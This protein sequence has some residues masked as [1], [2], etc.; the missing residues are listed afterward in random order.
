[1]YKVHPNTHQDYRSLLQK[2]VRRSDNT[3]VAKVVDC[4]HEIGDAAWL[5]RRTGVIIAEECWPLMAKWK[6]PKK[7]ETQQKAIKDILIQVAS[8]K[9]FKDAA[10]LGSLAYALSEG[11]NSVLTGS[12]EDHYI[13]SLSTAIK[14]AKKYWEWA[15]SQCSS[16][17][18]FRL[19]TQAEK[20]YRKGGWPWDRAFIQATAYLAIKNGIPKQQ[21]VLDAIKVK[22]PFWVALDKHTP[23]GKAVLREV[24]KRTGFSWRQLNWV[25]FYCESGHVDDAISSQWWNREVEWRLGKVGLS[26]DAAKTMWTKAQPEFIKLLQDESARLEK[27]FGE[28]ISY[29]TDENGQLYFLF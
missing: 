3:I 19:V 2:A 17:P 5:K 16:D 6:L 15:I 11:D 4:L 22:F 8:S 26:F 10:G 21:P 24:S 23:Q 20:A 29:P 9:K 28:S 25:S 18:M 7:S 12:D 1:M 27:I 13:K 14:D